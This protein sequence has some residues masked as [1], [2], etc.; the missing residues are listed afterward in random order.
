MALAKD[1]ICTLNLPELLIHPFS[2]HVH[3]IPSY[4]GLFTP[5]HSLAV[6]V[7]DAVILILP[8]ELGVIVELRVELAL[9]EAVAV[10]EGE[11]ANVATVYVCIIVD[12][13]V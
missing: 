13:S 4:A 3:C 10:A 8:V 11:G 2:R 9:D 6:T 7:L 1:L 5:V 12:P